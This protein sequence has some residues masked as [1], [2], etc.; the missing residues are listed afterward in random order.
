MLAARLL[1]AAVLLPLVIGSILWLDTHQLA[2]VM[3]VVLLL[4]SF[5]FA[6][7]SGIR[8]LFARLLYVVL[9]GLLLFLAYEVL[10]VDYSQWAYY[11]VSLIWLGI[12]LWL[13]AKR[14][15]IK[16]LDGISYMPLIL[17]LPLLTIAWMSILALHG[18]TNQGPYWVLALL[19]F[20]WMADTS[21]YFAGRAFGKH[22]LS[23]HVSPG[24]TIE[25]AIGGLVASLAVGLV[26]IL[27]NYLGELPALAFLLLITITVVV[28]IGGDLWESYCKRQ[29]ELK[30]SGNILPGHGGVLDRID[31]LIAAAPIFFSGMMLMELV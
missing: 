2:W 3:G 15:P 26:L 25:G 21:A 18:S 23:V 4:G 16:I 5:E 14:K 8:N 19:V 29:K 6:R 17:G 28:S 22:K 24:K 11:L 13:L 27:T 20:I 9:M 10:E 30:D 1:T 7:L 31:S 12:S